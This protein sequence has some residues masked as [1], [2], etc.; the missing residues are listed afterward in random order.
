MKNE[1]IKPL[2]LT[3]LGQCGTELDK[4][5]AKFM[6]I[7]RNIGNGVGAGKLFE[8]LF[9]DFVNQKM[10]D[11]YGIHLNLSNSS[12]IWD[13]I[14]S[15]DPKSSEKVSIITSIIKNGVDIETG[16]SKVLGD[17]WM[18]ISLK[19]YKED[20]CQITTDYSY[21]TYLESKFS[22]GEIVGDQINEFFSMLNKHDT[23]RYVIM[24]LNTY[25]RKQSKLDKIE[26][27]KNALDRLKSIVKIKTKQEL[28]I[29]LE[30]ELDSVVNQYTFRLLTFD[31]KF[32]KIT[33]KKNTKLTQ[34]D[35]SIGGVNYFKVLYGKNQANPFQ[36][37]IW[38]HNSKSIEYFQ[39]IKTGEYGDVSYFRDKILSTIFLN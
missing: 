20:A 36:R 35:L 34:Y 19:T 38:T 8:S 30:S 23:D 16:I 3:K 29:K 31:K 37:G 28:I 10:K 12:F 6:D 26:K 2:F 25:D 18:G 27:E 5:I 4:F 11:V 13:I 33:F 39:E 17:N 1:K 9:A 32:D 24:A 22:D 14:I 7:K 21:R 15:D